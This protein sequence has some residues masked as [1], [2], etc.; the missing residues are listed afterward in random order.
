MDRAAWVTIEAAA[1]QDAC[2]SFWTSHRF[3]T[4]RNQSRQRATQ[5]TRW[6]R[7]GL[8]RGERRRTARATVPTRGRSPR[9][10]TTDCSGCRRAADARA[11]PCKQGDFRFGSNLEECSETPTAVYSCA[12]WYRTRAILPWSKPIACATTARQRPPRPCRKPG[13]VELLSRPP[14]IPQRSAGR[15]KSL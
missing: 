15:P 2:G 13:S 7:H 10:A 3:I 11:A 9:T 1:R 4:V 6:A 5:P 14:A 12:G 8:G